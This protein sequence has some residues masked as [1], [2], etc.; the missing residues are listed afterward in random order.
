MPRASLVPR[1]TLAPQDQQ[2]LWALVPQ[3]LPALSQV[4][5]D[6]LVPLGTQD[7]A[8]PRVLGVAR[9]QPARPAPSQA[10]ADRQ[11]L[12]VHREIKVPLVLLV[13]LDT[14]VSRV[15]AVVHADQLVPQVLVVPPVPRVHLV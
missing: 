1:A 8:V 13:P 11:V 3:A 15:P 7:Q 4:P 2:V 12:Q 14:Q 5:P 6:V 9:V 10:L